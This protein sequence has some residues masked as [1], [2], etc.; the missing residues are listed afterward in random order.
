MPA[1]RRHRSIDRSGARSPVSNR[2]YLA[3][4]N[5]ATLSIGAI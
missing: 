4:S 2:S 3:S 5:L 1:S